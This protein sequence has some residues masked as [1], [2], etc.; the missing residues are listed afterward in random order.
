MTGQ[1][2]CTVATILLCSHVQHTRVVQMQISSTFLQN[3]CSWTQK[4]YFI[5]QL[6]LEGLVHKACFR[7]M[8]DQ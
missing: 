7:N 5:K 3:N 2:L 4:C 1:P 8:H 6:N